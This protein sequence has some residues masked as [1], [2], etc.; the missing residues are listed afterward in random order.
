MPRASKSG[1]RGLYVDSTGRRRIDLRYADSDGKPHRY[2]EVIP[3]GTPKR[4]AEKRA[5]EIL[6][7]AIT[8][9]L[10]KRRGPN[11]TTL[12]DAFDQYLRW[13]RVNRPK[14][15]RSRKS[16]AAVWIEAI[17]SPSVQQLGSG[18]LE[19]YK[20][21]RLQA[22]AAPA[23]VNRGLAMVKHMVGLAVRS[24]WE[25]MTRTRATEIGEVSMLVEPPGRQRPIKSAE[26]DALFATF[27][28]KDSRFA[29]RVVAASL[30]T[31]CR[32]GEILGLK[33][34]DLNLQRGFI[35]L[36]RTKQNRAHQ[37]VIS[38]PMQNLLTE[39]LADRGQE[40]GGHVFTSSRGTRYTVSGF[41]RHFARVAKRSGIPD[42]T[43]HDLRRHAAT[44]LVNSGERIEVVSKLLG[45][46]TVTATQRSYAHLATESTKAAFE[47]LARVAP[48]LPSTSI[49]Q[50]SNG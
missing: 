8:G 7:E 12:S 30:L 20:T 21:N 37:I 50:L 33:E 14:S 42:A 41:S 38:E 11:A 26:L 40:H 17:G 1:I 34:S 35:D 44:F 15:Y 5:Q 22:E 23:T 2:K 9:T 36:S 32:L 45:H 24:N 28:R 47:A 27:Q 10:T 18:L 16:I 3:N 31:G 29:R 39:A 4:A 48:A 46:S 49:N 43:Y 6:A 13:V 25:W 19:Q